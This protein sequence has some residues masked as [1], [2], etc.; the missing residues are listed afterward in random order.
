MGLS[1]ADPSLVLVLEEGL[2]EIMLKV[3]FISH[4]ASKGQSIHI[5]MQKKNFCPLML[6]SSFSFRD[7][8]FAAFF[9]FCNSLYCPRFFLATIFFGI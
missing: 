4:L 6:S 7:F 9:L 3:F 1:Y 8:W 5:C 2:Q